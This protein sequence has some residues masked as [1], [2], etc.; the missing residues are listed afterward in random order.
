MVIS[1]FLKLI[2]AQFLAYLA[3]DVKED[4]SVSFN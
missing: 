2:L 1:S 4:D 3:A